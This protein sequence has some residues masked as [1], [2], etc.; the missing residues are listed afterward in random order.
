MDPSVVVGLSTVAV[1]VSGAGPRPGWLPGRPHAVATGSLV[2]G[3]DSHVA[4]CVAWG[5][6]NW[7]HPTGERVSPWC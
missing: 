4:G 7:S 2:G 5:S 3:P 6:Q 1:L